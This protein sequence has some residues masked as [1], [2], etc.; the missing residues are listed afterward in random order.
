MSRFAPVALAVILAGGAL[1]P[2]LFANAA[3]PDAKKVSAAINYPKALND[4][5]EDIAS[6][7]GLSERILFTNLLKRIFK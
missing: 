5:E 4:K 2:V 6:I 3:T 1:T 7:N